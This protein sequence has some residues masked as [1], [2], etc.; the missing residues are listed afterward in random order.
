MI[1]KPFLR[2]NNGLNNLPKFS[3]SDL[4]AYTEG[5]KKSYSIIQIDKGEFSSQSVDID[6]WR[7]VLNIHGCNR[8]I[9]FRAIGSKTCGEEITKRII[10]GDIKNT[11][12][13]K[14]KDLDNYLGKYINHTNII[15][16]KG[17]SWENDVFT[18]KVILGIIRNYIF[19]DIPESKI[20]NIED[21][22]K[23]FYKIGNKLIRI[24]LIFRNLGIRFLTAFKGEALVQNGKINI[25]FIINELKKVSKS[26]SIK[27]PL[28][29]VKIKHSFDSNLDCYGKIFENLAYQLSVN[30]I[31]ELTDIKGLSKEIFQK[32]ALS[33]FFQ[34][35]RAIQDPYY[36]Q[37][38]ERIN[39]A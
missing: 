1:Q 29:F 39:V 8:K 27:R 17:Y 37:I 14:D 32:N 23:E 5:G 15:Y 6:F 18:Q 36:K 31:K 9:Y 16:T 10:S 34:E 33:S 22:F 38:A 28:K 20:I 25:Q 7:E 2:T 11:I 12:I 35:L 4:I 24:E 3:K 30:I 19:S 21:T 26:E 13:F